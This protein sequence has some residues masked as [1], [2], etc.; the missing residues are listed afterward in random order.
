MWPVVLLMDPPPS[1]AEVTLAG[2]F[3]CNIN[4]IRNIGEGDESPGSR[5]DRNRVV[6]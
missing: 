6:R 2:L 5:Y 1:I 4:D 3:G